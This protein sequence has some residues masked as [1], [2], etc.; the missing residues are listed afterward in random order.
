MEDYEKLGVFYLGRPYQIASGKPGDGLFLYDSKDLVTHAVC[1][2]MTGSGKTGLCISLIEEAA[3][4]GVP[5]IAIDPKGDLTN[6]M[7]TFP[8]LSRADFRPWVNEEDARKKG[9]TPDEYAGQQSQMWTNGLA[10]WGQS[11]DRIKRLRRTADFAIY[12]P[13]SQAGIPVSILKSFAAPPQSTIDDAEAFRERVGI[14]TSSLLGIIGI[15]VDP[16]R[17][18]EHIL[19]SNLLSRSWQQGQD[20]T[21]ASLIQQIQSPPMKTIGVIDLES[22]YPAKERF[23]LALAL[24][25]LLAAPGFENWLEG[26][27]LDIGSIMYTPEGKPRVAIFSIAHLNDAERMFFVSLLLNQVL[28]WMRGQS[29]TSSL[30]SIIYMDEIFGFFPP[31]ANPPSKLPLLTLLKQAR[32]FGVGVVLA[33]QNPVDLDYKGLANTGTWFIGRLQT[34]RDKMRVLEGLE[35]AAATAG[36]TWDR[37]KTEQIL[38]GLSNRIFLMNNVHDDRP[39]IFETRWAMSYLRGP[40]TRNQIKL[41]MDPIKALTAPGAPAAPPNRD[42][43]ARTLPSFT[44]VAQAVSR[45]QPPVLPP[46]VQQYFIPVRQTQ[47]DSSQLK[48]IPEILGAADV[49]FADLKT[50][51]NFIRNVFVSTPVSDSAD[52]VDWNQAR[53]TRLEVSDLKSA[54][55]SN[56]TFAE[57]PP[58]AARAD[59]FGF[60]K[61]E[62]AAWLYQSQKVELMKSSVFNEFSKLDESERDFRVR[63]QQLARER[64]DAAS[65]ELRKKY[66]PKFATLQERLRLAQATVQREKDQQRHQ[67]LQT[68]LSFGST[69]LGGFLGSKKLG[70]VSRAKTTFSGVGRS[71]KEGK[72]VDRAKDTVESVQQRIDQLQAEFNSDIAEL[73]AKFDPLTESLVHVPISPKKTDI[74]VQLVTLGWFPYGIANDGDKTPA[75]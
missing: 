66:A 53:E 7:L 23:E 54:P 6:L 56:A 65:D 15:E 4:D 42:S 28:G 31:V 33:T 2:G 14:T 13:G 75:W 1:V 46:K 45:C 62:F 16:I 67:Q 30:R 26:V 11:G 27:P 12:T 70:S 39:T 41:I 17:S 47:S 21:I 35:G 40:L 25:N 10:A 19:I 59:S 74:N 34:E 55:E 38:A 37:S 36:V 52:A 20:V 29:G 63:L 43:A 51:V 32:A 58:L 9:M 73:A 57:L 72:D 24:N 48:Y 64:R 8:G 69:L 50:G 60:W 49:R 71:M 18:R 3:M 5:T 22:F 61:R 68:V 44:N